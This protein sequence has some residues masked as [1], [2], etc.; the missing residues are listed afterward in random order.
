MKSVHKTRAKWLI[1][2][3]NKNINP[4]KALLVFRPEYNKVDVSRMMSLF[5]G[6]PKFTEA[7]IEDWRAIKKCIE[8][9]EDRNNGKLFS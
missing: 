4:K 7:D 2:F 8:R 3:A 9:T 6:T 1:Y 5:F